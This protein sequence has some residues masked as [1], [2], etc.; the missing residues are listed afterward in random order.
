MLEGSWRACTQA[1]DGVT[2]TDLQAHAHDEDV[3]LSLP[4]PFIADAI[5]ANPP[6]YA[7]IHIAE[8]LAVPLHIM[9]T[10]PWSP[11]G[12]FPHPLANVDASKVDRRLANLFSY[13]RMDFLT[14]EGL[15]DL[16]NRFRETTLML[17][18]VTPIWG[19]QI[20]PRLN[21]PFTYCWPEVLIPKPADWGS[22]I[23][24]SGYWF[25]SLA[26]SFTPEPALQEFLDN[27]PPPIYIG[28]GS[29]VVDDPEGLTQMI[30]DAVKI[31]GGKN[32]TGQVI[33][34]AQI[35]CV[36]E[37]RQQL[38]SSCY[39][40]SSCFQRVGKHRECKS[41]RRCFPNWKC[42][43]RLAFPPGGSRSSPWRCWYNCYWHCLR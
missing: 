18:P 37:T 30:F 23:T 29:I 42:T 28:F 11:T 40:A 25:L 39:S 24:I 26:S 3:L 5:I 14:W 12:A 1:G 35:F 38:T 21:V 6:S 10:M 22:H 41:S 15:A 32:L 43:S 17:D 36:K 4:P 31:A 9:F 8:K 13:T 7:H 34:E 19:H 16:I 2:E 20:L 27:G 33:V